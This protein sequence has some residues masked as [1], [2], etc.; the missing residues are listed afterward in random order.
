MAS[1]ADPRSSACARLYVMYGLVV[2]A[3]FRAAAAP[4]P[5]FA[6][7]YAAVRAI[8]DSNGLQS[9]PVQNVTSVSSGRISALSLS[10]FGLTKLPS[11]VGELGE[12]T[13][14]QLAD[15]AIAAVPSSIGDLAKL[16]RLVLSHNLVSLLPSTFCH[17]TNLTI[18]ELNDNLL[19]ALPDSIGNLVKLTG[20]YA[21]YNS[22]GA[23][24]NSIGGCSSLR[25]C[26]LSHNQLASLPDGI[27][28]LGNLTSL[29]VFSNRLVSLP[30]SLCYLPGFTYLRVDSNQLASLP[31]SIVRLDLTYLSIGHNRLCSLS[32]ATEHWL[33]LHDPF[34]TLSQ[35]CGAD[36]RGA[37]GSTPRA[38]ARAITRWPRL[39]LTAASHTSLRTAG[40]LVDATGRLFSGR[41]Q[42][43]GRAGPT[44]GSGVAPGIYL[45]PAST[46]EGG[47]CRRPSEQR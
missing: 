38:G 16:D 15:N 24:P 1:G 40:P 9:T 23:L 29:D 43:G 46:S 33:D 44:D 28:R 14:L 26:N 42:P 47:C 10:G 20:L 25:E 22:L 41:D 13:L 18:V 5:D 17:C 37:H 12:L 7:E 34:W 3:A 6:C 27:G 35:D 39:H 32:T 8:L 30:D 31:D 45:R 11:Q 36:I 2:A 21:Q 4:C 19:T